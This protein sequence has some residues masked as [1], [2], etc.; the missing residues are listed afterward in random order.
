MNSLLRYIIGTLT[1]SEIE[2]ESP[3]EL[4]AAQFVVVP[5]GELQAPLL[6][7]RLVHV[8]KYKRVLPVRVTIAFDYTCLL[9]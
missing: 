4:V 5:H 6:Q 9:L 7:V 2:P 3:Q 8:L 1:D